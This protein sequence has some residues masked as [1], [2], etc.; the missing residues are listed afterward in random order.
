MK[1]IPLS[2]QQGEMHI[3]TQKHAFQPNG[4]APDLASHIPVFGQR[5]PAWGL[6]TSTAEPWSRQT[7]KSES[8]TV[9]LESAGGGGESWPD[10]AA[11]AWCLFNL[12][13]SFCSVLLCLGRGGGEKLENVVFVSSS[14]FLGGEVN[15]KTRNIELGSV[16]WRVGKN[17]LGQTSNN[18]P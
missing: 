17:N 12:C 8:A 13:I 4:S 1:P 3:Q 15:W 14:F 16:S 7:N 9:D 11:V 18:P 2:N 6:P 5:N 10:F